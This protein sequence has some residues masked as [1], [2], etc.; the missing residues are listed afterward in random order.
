[1]DRGLLKGYLDQGLSLPQIGALVDRDPSTV[2]YWVQKHG[3][4]ANGQ[5]KYA[6]RGGLT[7]ESLS[8]SGA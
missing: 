5:D 6:P 3:L 7:R 4:V 1:M 8:F 2:G